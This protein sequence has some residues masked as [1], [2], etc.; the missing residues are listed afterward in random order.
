[1]DVNFFE[2]FNF[3]K[4]N[5]SKIFLILISIL[6]GLSLFF[7][8]FYNQIKISELNAEV[9]KRFGLVENTITLTKIKEIQELNS[10][11]NKTQ[12]EI[13]R[14]NSLDISISKVDCLNEDILESIMFTINGGIILSNLSFRDNIIEL[15]GYGANPNI[16]SEYSKALTETINTAD[17]H[18]SNISL[19]QNY[20]NFL[21]TLKLE[22]DT[23]EILY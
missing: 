18:I 7:V 4:I 20:Y 14:L 11:L 12:A 6:I 13:T 3:N 1:M 2:G 8:I 10:D 5:K 15:S 21:I 16:I 19:E 17:V 9:N 23:S 22:G